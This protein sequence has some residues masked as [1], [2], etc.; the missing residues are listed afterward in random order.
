MQQIGYSLIDGTG[1]ELQFWGD[2]VGYTARMP[3]I[4]TLPSGDQVHCPS[5]GVDYQGC[6][7]VSRMWQEGETPS[8]TY[9]DGAVV[10]TRP[11]PVTEPIRVLVPKSVIIDRL[12]SA[13]KLDAARAA[14]DAADLYTRERWNTRSA[15]YA[16][17]PTALALLT[18]IGA[19]AQSI[20][21]AE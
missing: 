15:I 4:V 12:H 11:K 13:G 9:V 14:L 16:D 6:Q 18:A 21:A 19:D 3:N 7:I 8:V 20:L 1:N 2:D 17:D 5:E 10:V